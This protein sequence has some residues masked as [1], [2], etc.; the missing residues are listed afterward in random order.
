MFSSP[1]SIPTS[2]TPM[3]FARTTPSRPPKRPTASLSKAAAAAF[4]NEAVGRLGGR[5]GVVRAKI[6][7]VTEVGIDLGDEN[8]SHER[9]ARPV[10]QRSLD[11]W[12]EQI[13]VV[14]GGSEFQTT[15]YGAHG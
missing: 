10:C 8:I 11:R 2:V 5:D 3:I 13:R 7:G 14:E 6:I 15:K 4:D 12:R 1:K 9:V